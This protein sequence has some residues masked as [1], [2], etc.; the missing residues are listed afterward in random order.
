PISFIL[1]AHG[2]VL[3]D[4]K[5]EIERLIRHRLGREAKVLAAVRSAGE[6]TLDDLVLLAYDD[7][8][9]ILHG[10][11]KRSLTAHLRKLTVDGLVSEAAGIWRLS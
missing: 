2:H 7:V 8:D 9:P 10:V 4:P 3:G 5:G 6:G 1:P 11:A